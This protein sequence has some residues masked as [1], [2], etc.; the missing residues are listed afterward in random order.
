MR[1]EKEIDHIERE[2]IF[3]GPVEAVCNPAIIAHCLDPYYDHPKGCPNWDMKDGCPPNIRFFPNVYSNVFE[4][5]ANAGIILEK[6]PTNFVHKV[7]LIANL[8]K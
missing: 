4:T 7:V 5:C 3:A 8:I 2:R 6:T 1:P